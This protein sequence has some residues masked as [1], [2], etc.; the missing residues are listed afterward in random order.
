VCDPV[1]LG[2]TAAVGG[3][4]QAVGGL[5]SAA[6]QKTAEVNNYKRKLQIRRINWDG[7]R[8]MY[9]TKL[10]EYDTTVQENVLSAS[11]AYADEQSRLNDLFKQADSA[12]LDAFARV[13]ENMRYV[14]SGKTAQRREARDLAKYG[15]D[16]AMVASNLIRAH[17]S[18]QSRVEGIREKLRTT[19]RGAYSKVQFKP[20][21]GVPPVKPNVD[22]TAANLA[23]IG[24][25]ASAV[26]SGFSTYNSLKAP[27][28]GNMGGFGDG[29]DLKTSGMDFYSQPFDY[30][31]NMQAPTG[32]FQGASPLTSGMNFDFSA[33]N[34]G[35]FNP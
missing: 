8:A 7:Q 22:M 10:A 20:Q 3:A 28:V 16:Q 24:G 15:R 12:A 18:Y 21:P 33:G 14:G 2:V 1:T 11:R 19:N 34:Y 17:E 29:I 13:M 26:S 23:F 31:L 32:F 30:N 27:D 25:M 9:G 5:K 6:D 35:L 4:A